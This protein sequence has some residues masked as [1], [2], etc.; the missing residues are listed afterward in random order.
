VL[1]DYLQAVCLEQ[2]DPLLPHL[3]NLTDESLTLFATHTQATIAQGESSE[4]LL[5]KVNAPWDLSELLAHVYCAA[6]SATAQR[7]SHQLQAHESIITPDGLWLS[8]GWLKI[9][10]SKDHKTGVLQREKDLRELKQQLEHIQNNIADS[11]DKLE[12]TER[13]LKEAEAQREAIARRDSN[14]GMELSLKNSEFSAQSARLEQQHRRLEQIRHEQQDINIELTKTIATLA[15]A[16][17]LQAQAEDIMAEQETTRQQLEA[18]NQE[19]QSSQHETDHAVNEARQQ[20]FSIKAKIESLRA[21]EQLTSKQIERLQLQHQQAV[22][23]IAQLENK[24]QHTHT[25]LAEEKELLANKIIEKNQLEQRLKTERQIQQDLETN[26]TELAKEH[27]RV[28]RALETE[29]ETLDK[30]RLDSQESKVRGQTVNEQLKEMNADA[31]QVLKNL[32]EFAQESV[33]KQKSDE[34]STQIERL[35]TINLTAIEEYK[36]QSERL[37][38]KISKIIRWWSSLF[39]IN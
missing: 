28:Q 21:S 2:I 12:V 3:P 32:P 9:Q 39:R 20:V 1:G 27:T 17:Q 22:A 33:W 5:N 7:L 29:K 34:L 38:R 26:I 18:L 35:G 8:A 15:E 37:A 24:Q 25:T 16:G 4:T 6:D 10:R 31:E 23:H 14:L 11:E 30:L 13:R 36:E 19:L